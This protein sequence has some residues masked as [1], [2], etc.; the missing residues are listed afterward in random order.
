MSVC[1][2]NIIVNGVIKK[3]MELTYEDIVWL[4][5]DFY[6]KN[7]KYPS[8]HDFC[9]KNNLPQQRIV[10]RLIKEKG[11][12]YADFWNSLGKT[13]HV[14]A[15]IEN[16]DIYIHKFKE[17]CNKNHVLTSREL[18]CNK[19]GLPSSSWF[20]ENCPDKN[21][22]NYSDFLKWCGYN[23]NIIIYEKEYISQQLIKYEKELGRAIRK[24]DICSDKI[25]FSFWAIQRIWG[26]LRNCRKEIGLQEPVILKKKARS[27]LEIKN[28]IDGILNKIKNEENRIVISLVEDI[29][30]TKYSEFFQFDL[31]SYTRRFNENNM[32]F[33]QYII[34]QGFKLKE[35]GCGIN[36]TLKDGEYVR[37]IFEYKFTG[38][39]KNELNMRYNQDYFKDVRYK[40]FTNINNK[41][42]CD[43]MIKIK[44]ICLYVEI[45]GILSECNKLD[46]ENYFYKDKFKRRY[47]GS[48]KQK[49][50]LLEESNCEYIFLF[51][52]DISSGKYKDLIIDFIN[53]TKDD[54]NE[55]D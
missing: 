18:F 33:K 34:K 47:Q 6:N 3:T 37:S 50:Q 51:P 9:I 49:K 35:I 43:Y 22:K 32:D 27:F 38:F 11:L 31:K 7:N 40:N 54:N 41:M 44:D 25:G 24:E 29:S 26:S 30:K 36:I 23:P 5:K 14:R 45:A 1:G 4:C 21:V 16:Y 55:E 17:Y 28:N 10:S 20:V 53:K 2:I 8:G 48:L 39:L 52:C 42:T 19:L 15:E 46:W 13:K 12:T